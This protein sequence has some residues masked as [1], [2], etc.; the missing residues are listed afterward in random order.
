MKI[1][2]TKLDAKIKPLVEERDNLN[3][4]I[5][6]LESSDK[7]STPQPEPSVQATTEQSQAAAPVSS[8][9]K[10]FPKD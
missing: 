5:A 8:G 1:R 7:Q 3:Q 9:K 6:L 2:V 10:L 4:A